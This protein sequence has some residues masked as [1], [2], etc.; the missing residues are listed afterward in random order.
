[1]TGAELYK[2][3]KYKVPVCYEINSM[4]GVKLYAQ[5]VVGVIHTRDRF[6]RML[7]SAELKDDNGC[8]VRVAA[9]NV[10]CL[11]IKERL[12]RRRRK[13]GSGHGV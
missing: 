3:L 1:M 12:E 7:V 4:P 10:H 9:K 13:E 5:C 6:G 8:L 2:L 11:N